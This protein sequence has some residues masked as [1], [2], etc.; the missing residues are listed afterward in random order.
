MYAVWR[1]G[2]VIWR[3]KAELT[4]KGKNP[5]MIPI[6]SVIFMHHNAPEKGFSQEYPASRIYVNF[7]FSVFSPSTP[8]PQHVCVCVL[9]HARVRT[10]VFGSLDHTPKQYTS[11][12]SF[13][14]NWP[15]LF[16]ED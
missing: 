14:Q 12:I 6:V 5:K 15:D 1:Q 2:C 7:L 4:L 3:K 8:P 10:H 9:A 13:C 16:G 11:D